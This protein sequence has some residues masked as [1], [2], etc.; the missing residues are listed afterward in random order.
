LSK[1][2]KDLKKDRAIQQGARADELMRDPLINKALDGM[3]KVCFDNFKTS[4]WKCTE[5]REEL[6]KQMSA[7]QSFRSQFESWI[8]QGRDARFD[9]EQ[10]QETIV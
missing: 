5:E 9:S 3:E 2:K 4:N 10:Q 8:K 7:I 1:K 6:H